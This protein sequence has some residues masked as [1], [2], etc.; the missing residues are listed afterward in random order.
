MNSSIIT[1]KSKGAGDAFVLDLALPE[2]TDPAILPSIRRGI[3]Q[4][5]RLVL[6]TGQTDI[7]EQAD[8]LARLVIGLIEPDLGLVEERVD[9]MRTVRTM[10]NDG[11]WLS[12][13]MLNQLQWE[14]PSNRSMPASDWKRRGRIFSVNFSGKEYFPR[15]EFDALYK[16]LPVIRDI[17]KAFGSVADSWKLAAWFHFPNGWI[18]ELRP[19]GPTPIAPKDALD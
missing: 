14:P 1:A 16:P 9:R 3:A 19:E 18:V 12:S 2:G 15:Y 10:F 5:V 13:E 6:S 17:L 8:Q 11:E 7:L 4:A